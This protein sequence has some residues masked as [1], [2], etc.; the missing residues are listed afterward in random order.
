MAAKLGAALLIFLC[1]LFLAAMGLFA[2]GFL[3]S[4]E[5][6]GIGLGVG[7]ALLT[8]LIL[9]TIIRELRFGLATQ[10]LGQME[11]REDFLSGV[12]L[13]DFA[14]VKAG[15]EATPDDWRAWYTLA[16][17]YDVN[18]DRRGAR[19]AMREAITRFTP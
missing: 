17:S 4:G 13:Q 10:R 14:A 11:A 16:L 18:R 9:W 1:A 2:W 6:L 15:V 12:N 5:P 8:P 7:I 19:R 3:V